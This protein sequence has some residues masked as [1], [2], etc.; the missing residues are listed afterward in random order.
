MLQESELLASG[1]YSATLSSSSMGANTSRSL[2]FG[3]LALVLGTASAVVSCGGGSGGGSSTIGIPAPPAFVLSATPDSATIY[4]NTTFTITVASQN[5]VAPAIVSI[6]S[7]P[8]G[9]TTT[10]AFPVTI[11]G[12]GTQLH[13]AADKNLATGN[14]KLTLSGQSGSATTATTI[15]L[16]ASAGSPP[17]FSLIVP[18]F[19][20]LAVP[21]GGTNQIKVASVANSPSTVAYDIALSLAPLP[22]G[23]NATISPPTIVPGQEVT[24]AISATGTA[25]ISQNTAVTLTGTPSAAVPAAGARFLVEITSGAGSVPNNRTDYISTAGSPYQAVFDRAHNIIFSSNPAW[26]RVDVISNA[27]HQVIAKIPIAA[28]PRG[29]D[30]SIDG[31]RVWVAT[32]SQQMFAIDPNTF[33]ATK[34]LLPKFNSFA[35]PESWE[36]SQ[37]YCLADGTIGLFF[38]EATGN[39]LD[40][41]AIWDPASNSLTGI[42]APTGG[43]FP[44]SW[45][46]VLR[47]GDGKRVYSFAADSGGESFY[48]DVPNKRTSAPVALT[49]YAISAAVNYDASRLAVYYANCSEN[50]LEMYDSELNVIGPLPGGGFGGPLWSGGMVFTVDDSTLYEVS[51]PLGI[52]V[53]FNID[54]NS[55]EIRGTAPAL[56]MIPVMTGLSSG[57]FLGVP[58]AVDN[59]GM[60]LEL[61]DYGLSFDDATFFQT[62]SLIQPASPI[63]MQHMSPYFG[64]LTGGTESGGFGN[65]FSLTPDVWYGSSRGTAALVTGNLSITSPPAS[66]QGPVNIKMLFPDGIQ[67]FDPL[68]FSY[69]PLLQYSL[70]TGAPPQGNVAGRVAG[71]GLPYSAADTTVTVGG[72]TTSITTQPSQYPPFT[73]E[74]FPSTFLDFTIPPG[75]PGWK[76]IAIQTADGASTLPHSVYYAQSVNDYASVDNF[77]AVLH[78]ESRHQLYLSAGDHIDVFSLVSDQFLSPLTPPAQG[79]SKQ[80]TGLSLTPDGSRLLA[81]DRTDGTLAV[82]SLDHSTSDFFV[83][84]GAPDTSDTRCLRGPLYVAADRNNQAYVAYGGVPGIGCGP[85]GDLYQVD[86]GTRT[87]HL[88]QVAVPCAIYPGTF[89][90]ANVANSKDG[91]VVAFGGD[92]DGFGKF[93]VYDAVAQSYATA[94]FYQPYGAEVSADGNVIA[95]QFVFTDSSARV[96]GRAV[97]PQ[98]LYNNN[99]DEV[100]FDSFAANLLAKPKLNDSGSLY[101]WAAPHGFEIVDVLHGLL[102]LR[103]SL[104]ENVSDTVAPIAIDSGGSHVYLVTDRGLAIVDLGGAPLAIGHLSAANVVVGSQINVRGSG[105]TSGITAFVGTQPS[106]VSVIDE[107][108]LN[109]TIPSVAPGIQSFS[110]KNPDGAVYTLENALIVN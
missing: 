107:N 8:S 105:F 1:P 42:S 19:T 52:P 81:A 3:R 76:D 69:G 70:V 97:H 24:V 67:V 39:T 63:F 96:V 49:G 7:L 61:E 94:S 95:T 18:G 35:G 50:C 28:I 33:T 45:S 5:A 15:S 32:E 89:S 44:A 109:V 51:N 75:S 9:I 25:P 34:Y 13:F 98:I 2:G 106:A 14:Y 22:P 17:G 6:G 80:F 73:G 77:T 72:R 78:D 31:S 55:L 58:F 20:E 110:L 90:G 84:L 100:G 66:V 102:Q 83:S 108:T 93:C 21:I 57:F 43:Q 29:I 79:G 62:F 11:S 40:H 91:S 23:T 47:S 88:L 86:L 68:F 99:Y 46:Y 48:Y 26:N 36:G 38:A 64:P 60:I 65:A 4:P 12:Q 85:G 54:P 10:T 103:F 41:F 92:L 87:A 71:Y 59:S 74:P 30:I 37:V 101:Y 56:G 27:S 53:I 104:N 82:I 16:T